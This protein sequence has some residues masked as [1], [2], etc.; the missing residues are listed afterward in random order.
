MASCRRLMGMLPSCI[1]SALR[2]AVGSQG[3]HVALQASAASSS[4]RAWVGAVLLYSCQR[5]LAR[6][7]GG[8]ELMYMCW[9]GVHCGKALAACQA[10]SPHLL[11][12]AEWDRVAAASAMRQPPRRQQVQQ[13]SVVRL[14]LCSPAL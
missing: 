3:R 5:E 2:S 12:P 6:R 4:C 11:Q 13:G 14:L 1:F 8:A 9:H 10:C 7:R